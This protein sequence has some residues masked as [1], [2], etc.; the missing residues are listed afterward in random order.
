MLGGLNDQL[1]ETQRRL[2]ALLFAIALVIPAAGLLA[3]AGGVLL[4]RWF[5]PELA[6]AAAGLFLVLLAAVVLAVAESRSQPSKEEQPAKGRALAATGAQAEESAARAEGGL[7]AAAADPA[8]LGV[9]LIG[10]LNDQ[11]DRHPLATVTTVAG[12][13]CVLASD[14][15]LRRRLVDTLLPASGEKD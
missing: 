3:Y 2:M 5:I 13:S 11:L 10:E 1:A 8:P 7:A 9:T 4:S 14:D 15:V 6:F 12:I